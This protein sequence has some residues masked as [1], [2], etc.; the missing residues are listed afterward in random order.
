[1]LKYFL[2]IGPAS[3]L[4][5]VLLPCKSKLAFWYAEMYVEL[6]LPLFTLAE[7]SDVFDGLLR[8]YLEVWLQL[9]PRVL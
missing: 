5:D 8:A 7:E 6:Y 3:W 1:M 2:S 4:Y 9:S